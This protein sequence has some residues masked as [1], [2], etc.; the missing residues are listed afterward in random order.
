MTNLEK[1]ITLKSTMVLNHDW[2]Q[3]R[4]D[5]IQL[6]NGNVIDDFFVHIK[7]DVALVLAVTENQEI[8]F[9]QQYRHAIGEFFIELPAG[10]FNPN[11]ESSESAAL[12]ELE[13]ETGY[14]AKEIKKI[15]VLYDRPSKD[16]NR[17]HLFLA[18]NV[19]K[20]GEQKLDMTEEIKVILIPINEVLNKIYQGE[21]SVMG[22]VTALLMGLNLLG[23]FSK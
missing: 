6:P 14:V 4:R 12:R 2:C 7:P 22:T 21:I 8:I 15:A 3:V 23:D 9:V 17:T 11:Q 5:E 1:W 16:T 18:E 13:E 19:V 20:V 10:T